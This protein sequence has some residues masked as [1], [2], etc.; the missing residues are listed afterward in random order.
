MPFLP[1]VVD[2]NIAKMEAAVEADMEQHEQ[3]KPAIQKLKF[4]KEVE[5]FLAQKKYH[6]LFVSAGGLGVLKVKSR[7]CMF[8]TSGSL[9][10]AKLGALIGT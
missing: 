2:D 1:Q 9:A 5:D 4:L 6:E 10:T 7:Q 3:S 8:C